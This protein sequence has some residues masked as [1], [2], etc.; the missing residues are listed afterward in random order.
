MTRERS[1]ISSK[2]FKMTARLLVV[3]IIGS[4]V[5]LMPPG[6]SAAPKPP[7]PQPVT[8]LSTLVEFTLFGVVERF[9]PTERLLEVRVNNPYPTEG[10][11][12][13]YRLRLAP[14]VKVYAVDYISKGGTLESFRFK[15]LSWDTPRLRAG[16]WVRVKG[17]QQLDP[18]TGEG[19]FVALLVAIDNF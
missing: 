4:S 2:R 14:S 19:T 13:T 16:A 8:P 11:T 10:N 5:W 12:L 18:E 15:T 3:L 7:T 1:S 17:T 9:V 6:G